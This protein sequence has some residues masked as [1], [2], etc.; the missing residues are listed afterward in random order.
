LLALRARRESLEPVALTLLA[1][2]WMF[3]AWHTLWRFVLSQVPLKAD[4]ARWWFW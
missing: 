4:P 1:G 2:G 3:V